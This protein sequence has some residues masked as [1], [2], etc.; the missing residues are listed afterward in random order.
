MCVCV[1]V[2]E[3]KF[4]PQEG[5]LELLSLIEAVKSTFSDVALSDLATAK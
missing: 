1:C 2:C 4:Y 3:V 5:K